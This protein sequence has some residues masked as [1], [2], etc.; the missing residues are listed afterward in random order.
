MQKSK[1]MK[2]FDSDENIQIIHVQLGTVDHWV[3]LSTRG[4]ENGEV[5]L[6]DSLQQRPSVET[7]K[8]IARYLKSELKS[9]TIK[10]INVA[11]Q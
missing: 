8:V 5:E 1:Y 10:V 11:L 4:C 6:Y 9:I 7:Q 3:T 2:A